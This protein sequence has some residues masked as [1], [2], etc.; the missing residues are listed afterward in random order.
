MAEEDLK[1]Q[2][3][4]GCRINSYETVESTSSKRKAIYQSIDLGKDVI[5][6]K[7]I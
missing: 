4:D 1:H 2:I 3:K 7:N 5:K 6:V